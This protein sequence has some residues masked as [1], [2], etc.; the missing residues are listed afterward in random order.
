[1][2]LT[3]PPTHS[4]IAE[5]M[6]WAQGAALG[7]TATMFAVIAVAAIGLL[8]LSGRLELRRG[9]TVVVGCFILF[10]ASSIATA[11]NGLAG[12]GSDG[13][14]RTNTDLGQLPSHL[15]SHLPPSAYDPYAG[16]SVP[17]ARN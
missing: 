5:G 13:D 10:G 12:A 15:Q 6:M 4:P 3:E 2:P 11:L 14:R 9:I 17:I 1:M 8:M 7:S 16:A